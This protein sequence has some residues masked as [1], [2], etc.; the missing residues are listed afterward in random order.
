[1]FT[2]ASVHW[3]DRIV[4]TSS[5]SGLAW[6]SAQ[7][8]SGYACSRRA[9]ILRARALRSAGVSV[10][11]LLALVLARI[12]AIPSAG[13][14]EPNRSAA[15]QEPFQPPD[16]VF[17]RLHVRRVSRRELDDPGIEQSRRLAGGF[18][19]HRIVNAVHDES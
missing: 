5:S 16:E 7:V 17:G 8:A 1:M 19:R 6:C 4:A 14:D 10:R 13:S 3:A 9:T 18:D 11:R 15:G 2:R 12:S